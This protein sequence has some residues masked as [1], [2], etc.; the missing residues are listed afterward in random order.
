MIK[1][2]SEERNEIV[3]T[4]LGIQELNSSNARSIVDAIVGLMSEL[5]LDI[6]QLM[7]IGTDN[8]SVMVGVNNGVYRI[9]KEE[10]NLPHLVLNRCVCHS[11]QLAV[12]HASRETL[13][14]TLNT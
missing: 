11:L 3:S 14:K 8:A 9:L 12:S 5:K 10:Y 13:P 7:G 1:Y 6:K 4:F 2:L